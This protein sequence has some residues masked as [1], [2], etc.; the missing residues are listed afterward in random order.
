MKHQLNLRK[1]LAIYDLETTG[2]NIAKDRIIEIAIIKAMPD[3]ELINKT[4][5]INPEMPIPEESSNIHHIFDEDVKDMPTFKEVAKNFTQ[6]LEGC[7]LAG[8]NV[9]RFDVPMLVEEFLR[10]DVDFSIDNR[11]LIDAQRI[12]HLMEPRNLS[13]AYKFY[14]GEELENAHSAE[15]DTFAT[16]KV[17]EAQVLRYEGQEIKNDKGKL[18]APVKNDM[19]ALHEITAQKM[20]DLAGRFGYNSK[21]EEVFKFG[22]H[23]DKVIEKVLE[24]EPSYYDWMMKG[25]F[26]LDT[27]RKLTE[28]KLRGFNKKN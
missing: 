8:F 17:L 13:A 28:I 10:A 3:G 2:I 19:D 15:A 25:D 18:Y 7:D 5:R 11:R 21:G 27:K 16:F 26:P 9:I 12:F 22:K 23:R 6:F 1:P 24:R 4:Q 20:V 14:C